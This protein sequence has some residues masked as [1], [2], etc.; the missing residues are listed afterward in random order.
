MTTDSQPLIHLEGVKKVFYTDEVET[1]ALAGHP[2]RDQAGRVHLDRRAVRLRQVHAAV[3]SRPARHA[4]R[5]QLHAERPAGRGP[6]AVRTRA[7]PQPR[8]RLHLPELQPDRR[9]DGLRERRA[10]AHLSRHEVGRAQ[11]TRDGRPREGADGASRQAPAQPALR[12]SAAAR[13]GR[14]RRR[15]LARRSCWRTSRRATSTP[16]TARPSWI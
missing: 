8:D 6:A 1:H 10:A 11:G 4:D 5:R 15:R 3:D 14:P 2:P 12:R 7:R 9:P 13:R 16:R